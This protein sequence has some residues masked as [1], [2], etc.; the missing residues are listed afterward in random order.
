[1]KQGHFHTESLRSK[2]VEVSLYH[3]QDKNSGMP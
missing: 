3:L 1:M 2:P